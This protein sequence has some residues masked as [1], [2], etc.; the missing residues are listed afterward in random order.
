[1]A[2]GLTI[3]AALA[4]GAWLNALPACD[5]RRD[6]RREARREP[7]RDLRRDPANSLRA[8]SLALLQRR[9]WRRLAEHCEDRG[10]LLRD[11]AHGR[12]DLGG[13]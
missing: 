3:C 8:L 7:R 10:L 11:E 6:P 12:D 5:P 9:S 13:S 1:M 2:L 4:D